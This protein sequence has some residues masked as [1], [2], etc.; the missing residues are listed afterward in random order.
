MKRVTLLLLILLNA[1]FL[2]GQENNEYSVSFSH[3]GLSVKDVD[4]SAKFYKRL[5]GLQ[6]I[7]DSNRR[8][9]VI[10]LLLGEGKELHLQAID[11][12][13]MA[14]YITTHFALT[15]NNFDSF[16]KQAYTMG[17]KLYSYPSGA[18]GKVISRPGGIRKAY[19]KDLDK[20]W[21]EVISLN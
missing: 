9:G 15:V 19:I 16:L 6:E 10:W 1:D 21:I 11:G 13:N 4:T 17:V 3:I 14:Q 2:F 18:E 7:I 12:D 5:F 8:E 20:N